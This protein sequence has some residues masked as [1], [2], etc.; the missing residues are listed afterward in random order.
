MPL[1]LRACVAVWLSLVGALACR[2]P[3][4]PP[5]RATAQ[6]VSDA[7]VVAIILAANNSGLSYSRLALERAQH[8]EVQAFAE[9]MSTDHTLL[10]FL[11]SQVASS[12]DLSPQDDATSLGM[13][14]ASATVRD[15]LRGLR[16]RAFDLTYMTNE[17]QFHK[18][19]LA[20]IDNVLVPSV[21]LPEL[22]QYL[23][24]MRPAVSAHLAHAEQ[25]RASLPARR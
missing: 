8:S 18:Y 7:N 23:T 5:T 1:S 14:D 15:A 9:R 4:P 25:V 12:L 3:F 10:N 19:L 20:T 17:V 16:G 13:R 21:Q 2:H 22:R 24:N 11:V 6:R